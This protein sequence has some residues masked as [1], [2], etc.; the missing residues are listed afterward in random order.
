M[1]QKIE[2]SLDLV[3]AVLGYLGTQ[4]YEKVFQLIEAIKREGE[5]QITPTPEPT[6]E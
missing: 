5:V 6:E 3:N 2:L 1:P 4:P